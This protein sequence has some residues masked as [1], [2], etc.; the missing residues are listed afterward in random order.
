MSASQAPVPPPPPSLAPPPGP[1]PALPLGPIPYMGMLDKKNNLERQ[2]FPGE[3]THI[4]VQECVNQALRLHSTQRGREVLTRLAIEVVAGLVAEGS[5]VL[6][7]PQTFP[8]VAA[9]HVD[10]FLRMLSRD[11]FTVFLQIRD[12][13]AVSNVLPWGKGKTSLAG[14]STDIAGELVV[15]RTVSDESTYPVYPLAP[16]RVCL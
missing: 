11:F 12:D 14:Y 2:V 6:V 8:G 16:P 4:I 1:A 7:N 15:N 5:P 10:D 9:R 3:Y 13:D